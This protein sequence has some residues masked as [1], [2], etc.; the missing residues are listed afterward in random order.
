MAQQKAEKPS[1][2]NANARGGKCEVVRGVG[3]AETE[4][5]RQMN[6]QR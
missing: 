6:E 4:V 2:G 5:R 1:K 3:A